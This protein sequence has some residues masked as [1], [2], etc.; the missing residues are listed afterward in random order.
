MRTLLTAL[1]LSTLLPGAAAAAEVAAQLDRTTAQVGDQVVLTV[2]A[3]GTMRSVP[4][5]KIETLQTDFDV[6]TAGQSQ[7]VSIVNGQMSTQTS[8]RYVLIPKR[9]GTFTIGPLE[10]RLGND[11]LRTLP[12]TLTVGAAP[13]PPAPP[14]GSREEI[15]ESKG[16]EDLFVRATVDKASV[17]VNEQVTLRVRL[18][19]R[20]DLLDNPGY[21]PP[22]VEGFWKEDLTPPA[23]TVETVNGKRY[24]VLE[25]RM[26][27]FPTR[28]GRLTIGEAVLECSVADRT[29]TRDPFSVF[30]GVFRDGKRI[31]LRSR[32]LTV[33]VKRL[34]PGAPPGFQG[35]VG[36]YRLSVQADRQELNQ[37]EPLTLTVRVSGEGPVRTV[38]EIALPPVPSFRSYPSTVS[39]DQSAEEG[40]IRGT[41]TQQFVLVPLRAGELQVPPVE[42]TYFSPRDGA[43]RTARSEPLTVHATAG[44]ADGP[45]S[46]RGAIEVVGRD[47]R[48]IETE[49]PRFTSARGA[50]GAARS[51]L[52]FLPAPFLG[53]LG[54][55]AWD[56]RR[57][58]QG[59]DRVG[60]RRALAARRA[61]SRLRAARGRASSDQ[62]AVAGDALRGYL[63]DR[64]DLPEAGLTP[65]T[66]GSVLR[67]HGIEESACLEL[68]ERINAARYAPLAPG[69]AGWLEDAARLLDS[70]ERA[71]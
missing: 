42:F 30:G 20:T 22:T 23:P 59:G 55:R 17:Y 62:A 25:V 69:A 48:F 52:A 1:V 56:A 14:P 65:D 34:P 27:L 60:R 40:V 47:I 6:Y 2:Q 43:Y 18:Y 66:V 45:G 12:L 4:E 54:I 39:Q 67:D 33:A 68:L 7:S 31:V 32:P 53:Y 64:F 29:Q 15:G 44:A 63:A 49:V 3:T 8:R 58:R 10:V 11:V 13:P 9:E 51:W 41:V 35:A 38:G 61:R 24:R 21:S 70:L 28:P 16:T 57:R 19:A 5:V 71:T 26:A 46:A 50:W 37:T 36:E